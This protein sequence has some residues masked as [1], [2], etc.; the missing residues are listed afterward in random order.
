MPAWVAVCF[1]GL[2]YVGFELASTT[3]GFLEVSSYKRLLR[4]NR[5]FDIYFGLNPSI[6]GSLG[7]F[8]SLQGNSL[9]RKRKTPSFLPDFRGAEVLGTTTPAQKE[10]VQKRKI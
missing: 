4:K 10:L 5:K 9:A 2:S 6:F 8:T 7:I 3:T 1:V